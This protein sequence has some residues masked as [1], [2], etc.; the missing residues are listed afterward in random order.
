MK[1]VE[2]VEE[3]KKEWFPF[4]V[5]LPAA[6]GPESRAN[7]PTLALSWAERTGYSLVDAVIVANSSAETLRKLKALL[8]E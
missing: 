2:D 7:R 3:A 6:G 8:E 4:K 5:Y 1:G